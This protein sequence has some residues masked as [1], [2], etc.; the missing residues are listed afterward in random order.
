MLERI[1]MV[2]KD[3]SDL[4]SLVAGFFGGVVG[5]LDVGMSAGAIRVL[6]EDVKIVLTIHQDLILNHSSLL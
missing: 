6:D 5:I 1:I 3:I 2:N 4:L